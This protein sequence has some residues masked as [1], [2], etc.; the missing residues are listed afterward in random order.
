MLRLTFLYWEGCLVW[1]RHLN[2]TEVCGADTLKPDLYK[3]TASQRQQNGQC[4]AAPNEL[5]WAQG[6]INRAIMLLV[7]KQWTLGSMTGFTE[8]SEASACSEQTHRSQSTF[9][10]LFFFFFQWRRANMLKIMFAA[11]RLYSQIVQSLGFAWKG[12]V[13]SIRIYCLPHT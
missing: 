13:L 4:V 12:I 3:L 1:E 6:S 11:I 10:Y 9:I 5:S 2:C 8:A 7:P